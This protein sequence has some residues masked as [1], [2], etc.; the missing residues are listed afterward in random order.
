MHYD[1]STLI[2][3]DEI[4]E[5]EFSLSP[6]FLRAILFITLLLAIPTAVISFIA[7]I[8]VLLLGLLYWFYMRKAKHYALT[9]RRIILVDDFLGTNVI[10]IDYNQITDITVEQSVLDEIGKWGTLIITTA[11]THAPGVRISFVADPKG[12][13]QFLDM[14]RDTNSP[15]VV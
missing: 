12:L 9:K 4:I 13:K 2:S 14:I 11:G 7:G 1:W 8:A 6:L 15:A 5:K 3:P 10:S